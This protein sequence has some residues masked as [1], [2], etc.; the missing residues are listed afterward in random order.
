MV[1]HCVLLDGDN[2]DRDFNPQLHKFV[3]TILTAKAWVTPLKSGLT[4][5]R[6]EMS[7]LVLCSRL[8][9]RASHFY[10]SGFA[11]ISTLGDSTCVISM[12]EKNATA[13][14]PFIHARVS[15]VLSLHSTMVESAEVEEL[16]HVASGDNIADICTRRDALLAKLGPQSSWQQGPDWLR[17]P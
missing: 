1:P 13:F 7:G 6:S 9:K 4:I 14:N 11:S 16:Q 10:S 12:L 8:Q 2:M 5:P 15:K 3:S 17:Q